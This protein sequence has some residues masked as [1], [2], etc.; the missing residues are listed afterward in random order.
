MVC[1]AK[2]RG[3]SYLSG[4]AAGSTLNHADHFPQLQWVLSAHWLGPLRQ[5]SLDGWHHGQGSPYRATCIIPHAQNNKLNLQ[6]RF[7]GRPA[8]SAA[9][10]STPRHEK[11]SPEI[12]RVVRDTRGHRLCASPGSSPRTPLHVPFLVFL[13][14][15]LPPPSCDLHQLDDGTCTSPRQPS[16]HIDG[17]RQIQ[18]W[19][20]P[21][22]PCE[23]RVRNTLSLVHPPHLFTL[24][25]A[26]LPSL[27]L[28]SY[29]TS[30]Q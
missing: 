19:I 8:C 10:F 5:L 14:L 27:P 15:L 1:R 18:R 17:I 20:M 23:Y 26:P 30:R 29:P 22:N 25:S 2:V 12:S 11:I 21:S 9:C 3:G 13:C 24:L 4:K 6:Y 28:S 7:G 16:E